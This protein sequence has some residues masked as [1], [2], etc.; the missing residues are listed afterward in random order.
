MKSIGFTHSLP[1]EE[2][3]SL[4]E[5]ET[6]TPTPGANDLLVDIKAISVNPADAKRRR[7]TAAEKPHD[8]P[9]VV[10]YDA[11]GVVIDTGSDVTLF[12][13]GD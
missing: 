13:I 8:E 2:D 3:Q 1:I 12:A 4:F 6:P 9:M 10:G 5:F 11:V 7:L